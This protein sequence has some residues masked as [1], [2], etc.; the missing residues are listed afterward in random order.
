MELAYNLIES[1]DVMVEN[2]ING[3]EKEMSESDFVYLKMMANFSYSRNNDSVYMRT[4]NIEKEEDKIAN[5]ELQ[6]RNILDKIAEKDFGG[7]S[8][9]TEKENSLEIVYDSMNDMV[10]KGFDYNDYEDKK[11]VDV[12]FILFFKL[13][14]SILTVMKHKKI[15][16]EWK[17]LPATSKKVR[18][19]LNGNLEDCT[20]VELSKK[21]FDDIKNGIDEVFPVIDSF[22]S[23]VLKK[24]VARKVVTNNKKDSKIIKETSSFN[25]MLFRKELE[26]MHNYQLILKDFLNTEDETMFSSLLGYVFC[27]SMKKTTLNDKEISS[28]SGVQISII[29][30]IKKNNE[31]NSKV[32][33][34]KKSISTYKKLAEFLIDSIEKRKYELGDKFSI[35]KKKVEEMIELEYIKE[36][37]VNK[38]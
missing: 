2:V 4:K 12:D 37:V 3:E 15:Y 10:S 19:I 30:R 5:I 31:L 25:L 36:S 23:S 32:K 7:F 35:D 17:A 26:L 6:S 33:I 34:N 24:K 27:E 16:T 1:L 28:K 14:T 21:V 9:P 18:E 20:K 38:K 29:N 8:V 13:V 22:I 11:L